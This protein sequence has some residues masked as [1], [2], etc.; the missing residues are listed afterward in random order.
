VTYRGLGWDLKGS[1]KGKEKM[2]KFPLGEKAAS[3]LPGGK[4]RT[5]CQA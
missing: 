2:E 4:E 1:S 3:S 5:T